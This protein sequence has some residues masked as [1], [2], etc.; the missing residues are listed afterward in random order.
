[1]P[2]NE[3][4]LR[5]S[6]DVA[7]VGAAQP[8]GKSGGERSTKSYS[9]HNLVP[10]MHGLAGTRAI[11]TAASCVETDLEPAMEARSHGHWYVKHRNREM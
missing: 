7:K 11:S 3:G 1:M 10:R 2:M 6:M 5:N 9:E 8:G 4:V